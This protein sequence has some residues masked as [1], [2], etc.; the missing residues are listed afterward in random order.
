[1][2]LVKCFLPDDAKFK[3]PPSKLILHVAT[4]LFC[5]YNKTRKSPC[6][7]KKHL[8]QLLLKILEDEA[9]RQELYSAFLGHNTST[10]FG[11]YVLL[12]F[13]PTSG[14]EIT[15]LCEDLKYA[16]LADTVHDLVCIAKDLSPSV[17]T[18][19]LNFLSNTNK[20][21]WT[22]QREILEAEDDRMEHI[23][24]QIAACV[25]LQLLADMNTVREAQ[26]KEPQW[27]LSF[28][29]SLFTK[30]TRKQQGKMEESECELLYLSLMLI[31]TLVDEKVKLEINLFKNFSVFLKKHVNSRIPMQLKSLIND[32]VRCIETYGTS[33][34]KHYQ[35]LSIN[36]ISSDKFDKAIKDLADPLI[37][38]KANGLVTLRKLIESQDPF[39]VKNRGIV[40]GLLQ[41]RVL[42]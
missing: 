29:K 40:L 34:K 41:V 9:K 35:D 18:Y 17:F 33:E 36:S 7:L 10:R 3:H 37:P 19:V 38:V 13:G 1:M 21:N 26:A 8:Q 32:V 12:E 5:L 30:Y 25:L 24:I 2:M 4:P 42:I 14:I 28:I 15:G 39:T 31:K 22:E 20:A 6:I 27:L 23:E 11:D 16:E